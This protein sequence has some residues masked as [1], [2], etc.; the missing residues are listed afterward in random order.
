MVEWSRRLPV[1]HFKDMPHCPFTPPP[2]RSQISKHPGQRGNSH[3][4][5]DTKASSLFELF[6][7][8][9]LRDG[10]SRNV[11]GFHYKDKR[12]ETALDNVLI[13][14]YKLIFVSLGFQAG[15]WPVL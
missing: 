5:K 14:H 6:R 11:F 8:P 2:R 7:R 3:S 10:S 1:S 12:T 9:A 13:N 15:Q 4:L